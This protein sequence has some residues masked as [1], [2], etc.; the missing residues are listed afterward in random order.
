MWNASGCPAEQSLHRQVPLESAAWSPRILRPSACTLQHPEVVSILEVPS[1]VVSLA[2][3][4]IL[5]IWQ[6]QMLPYMLASKTNYSKWGF[7]LV[8]LTM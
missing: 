8:G 5:C 2:A 6:F 1:T 3:V 7:G 4:S